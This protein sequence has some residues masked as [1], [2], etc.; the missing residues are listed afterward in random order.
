[1][2]NNVSWSDF[3]KTSKN[4]TTDFE[5]MCRIIFKRYF[6]KNSSIVLKQIV[7]NPGIETDP[8]NIEGEQIGFQ[9]KYFINSI[10]YDNILDSVEKIKQ[11]YKGKINKVIIFSN[12]N[13]SDKTKS[14]EKI[15]NILKEIECSYL[16][17]CNDEI[18]DLINNN[19]E[20]KN[21]KFSF[22][23]K[24]MISND[25]IR[26]KLKTTL[27]DLE[28]RYSKNCHF[29]IEE[30]MFFNGLMQNKKVIDYL[31]FLKE[32]SI[33]LITEDYYLDK[34]IKDDVIDVINNLEIPRREEIINI[35]YWFDSFTDSVNKINELIKENNDEIEQLRGKDFDNKI[36]N[37]LIKNSHLELL[38]NIVKKFD[39]KNNSHTKYL[40]NKILVIEGDAGI[41]KSH[42]LGYIADQS[43]E[44]QKCNCLLFLGQKIINNDKPQKQLVDSIGYTDSFSSL[45]ECLENNGQYD[46]TLSIIMID[47]INETKNNDVWK[48]YIN[49]LILEIEK[50]EYIK[51]VVSVRTTYKKYV[52]NDSFLERIE[53]G[54]IPIIK[55]NGFRYN[56]TEAI[57][58][59]F[60]FYKLPL[61]I[62]INFNRVF[63][64]PMLLNIYCKVSKLGKQYGS[65]N[66]ISL[67][68]SY[69]QCEENKIKD[70]HK[71]TN[72]VFLS[73]QIFQNIAE[74]FY[75]NN[76]RYIPYFTL[77]T[78]CSNIPYYQQL[79]DGL[80]YS[81][82]LLIY[83]DQN[84][85]SNIYLCYEKLCDYILA[86]YIFS[87]YQK[88]NEIDDYIVEEFFKKSDNKYFS[89]LSIGVFS[90]LSVFYNEK[91]NS[92]VISLIPNNYDVYELRII[93]EEYLLNYSLRDNKFI[94]SELFDSQIVPLIKKSN[95]SNLFF[96]LL[97]KLSTRECSLNSNYLFK[98]LSNLSLADRD[99]FW[100]TY[101][102][103]N[104]NKNDLLYNIVDFYDK[105]DSLNYSEN[106]CKLALQQL[107]FLLTSSNRKLRDETSCIIVKILKNRF[108]FIEWCLKR[109]ENI[110]DNYIISRLYGCCYGALLQNK[111]EV[112]QDDMISLANYIKN[113]I[114]EK[115]EKYCDILLRDYALNILEYLKYTYQINVD[116][117]QC[118]LSYSTSNIPN[119]DTEKLKE[120]YE[121]RKIPEGYYKIKMSLSPEHAIKN[122]TY[123]YGDFGRYVFQSA[124]Q[125]FKN[126]DI[127]KIFKYA[128][129][130]IIDVLGYNDNLSNYD[131]YKKYSRQRDDY[132]ERIGKKYQWIAMYHILAKVSDYYEFCERK[133]DFNNNKYYGTWQIYIRDFDP[134]LNLKN[135]N[136]IYELDNVIK[137]NDYIFWNIYDKNWVNI[138]D[139]G[140][141][142]DDLFLKD[143]REEKWISLYYLKENKIEN[144]KRNIKQSILKI[145]TA[146]LIK[147]SEKDNFISNI[148]EISFYGIWK[149]A[150]EES[151]I[152][153]DAFL[154]EYYW[155]PACKIEDN[156]FQKVEIEIGR[157]KSIKEIPTLD[158]E[159]KYICLISKEIETPINKTIGS[160]SICI[161][162]YLWEKEN[163]YSRE[164][165]ICIYLPSKLITK[166]LSLHQKEDGLWYDVDNKLCCVDFSYVKHSNIRGL[167]IREECL[168]KIKNKGYDILWISI[169]EKKCSNFDFSEF[170]GINEI[171]SLV[172]SENNEI[173]EI[174]ISNHN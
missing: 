166:L 2:D 27:K 55:L 59:Y 29:N 107:I 54:D 143:S 170:F 53:S 122:F 162:Q 144:K 16:L 94:S 150:T 23:N 91:Y 84:D 77:I 109:F 89:N 18:L 82:V 83:L 35:F 22:F 12:K 172:Y 81:K 129:Y 6:L 15:K 142:K 72:S 113:T 120:M 32:D 87:Q 154:K 138:N 171:S 37:L 38:L 63:E 36:T 173:K 93:L 10:S 76:V 99:A 51:I 168:E 155:A 88:K 49:E 78:K 1:M 90:A 140:S 45:L 74:Y 66:I 108:C 161:E 115:K 157:E 110:D 30:E 7:N 48:Q 50:Y 165:P 24:I 13:I 47:A 160:L 148:K 25:W 145:S 174:N 141:F 31:Y 163:D 44:D 64:N 152:D 40:K 149:Y 151:K 131:K 19:D 130:Y 117:D 111:F 61:S 128:Y 101:I 86:E 57:K 60:N 125:N 134:S 103:D 156:S 169:G 92:E 17:F 136:R 135:N 98:I 33:K 123:N 71:I 132:I 126:V 97:L 26:D 34:N 11:H 147:S 75:K 153:Y 106:E 21:L 4:L 104:F 52:F 96:E 80:I 164:E 14:F 133:T 137:S 127:E 9:A 46:G 68:Y 146:Y 43:L 118:K 8:I 20:Y 58:Y 158:S 159:N 56:L 3:E 73:K 85:V 121:N 114:F 112:L 69:I 116:I 100:T 124:L 95:S 139:F 5:R 79:I 41:G 102:N 67:Y 119:I 42:L 62:D 105:F 167:Y 70:F 39:L 28:P 65:K